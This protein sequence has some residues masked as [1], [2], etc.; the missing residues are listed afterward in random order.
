MQ[1]IRGVLSLLLAL[2]LT[3]CTT[4]PAEVGSA[5]GAGTNPVRANPDQPQITITDDMLEALEATVNE[6]MATFPVP[7]A[8]VAIAQGGRIVYAQGFGLRN[9]E[10]AEPVTPDTLFRIGS[11]TKPL[12]ALMLATLVD[13]D[14][15]QWDQPVIQIWPDFELPTPALTRETRMRDLLS[16]RTGLGFDPLLIVYAGDRTAAD[17]LELL[18]TLPVAAEPGEQFIY[19][20]DVYAATGYIGALAT[21][22]QFGEL[23]DAYRTLM[24]ERVFDPIGMASATL[25]HDLILH[26][27]NYAV[28]YDAHLTEGVVTSN[29]RDI[30]GNL[31]AGGVAA[32]AVDMARFLNTV[33][34]QGMTP[35]GTQVVQ[36]E[37]LAELWEPQITIQAETPNHPFIT[38]LH[39]GMGWI[40]Y[41]LAN[42]TRMLG[43][44]GAID[45]YSA[46]IACIPDA[47]VG[48]VVLNNAANVFGDDFNSLVRDRL[49]ELLYEMEPE[50]ATLYTNRLQEQQSQLAAVADQLQ[51]VDPAAV[52]AY[53]GEYEHGWRVE[54][55]EPE[56][57]AAD[58]AAPPTFWLVRDVRNWQM[59]AA[60]ADYMIV[61]GMLITLPISF[62]TENGEITMNIGPN[63]QGPPLE[64]VKK[65]E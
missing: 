40:S 6:A 16:M 63:P 59:M 48:I 23:Q 61:D 49:V 4:S 11:N 50:V 55:R 34:N 38:A 52:A 25:D 62:T 35:T 18:Q 7:G 37:T 19:N 26:S 27:S 53:V 57:A 13:D 22:A 44:D 42:G 43:H 10:S 56:G 51:P 64:Q 3:A 60:P 29:L 28:P 12:T 39:Y 30:G 36:A 24:Q 9:R 8:A 65:V 21:G 5:P 31:P 20:N 46:N 47:D 14:L 58:A 2:V 15:L 45:G 1:R 17:T 41:D 33:L 54:L 32:S